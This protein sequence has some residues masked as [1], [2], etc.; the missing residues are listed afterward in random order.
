MM[1]NPIGGTDGS[2]RWHGHWCDVVRRRLYPAWAW[3]VLALVAPLAW[4]AAAL[5]PS[6]RSAWSVLR[7]AARLVIAASGTP[8]AVHGTAA[9]RAA[10]AP[11]IFVCNHASYLDVVVVI[12][13]VP[14]PVRF[15]AKAELGR[16]WLSGPPLRRIGT[17][18]VERFDRRRSLA[19]YRAIVEATRHG[20]AVLFFPE[21]TFGVR[22][23][24]LPF[25]MGAFAA[26]IETG[27]CVRPIALTGTRALLPS[28]AR[29]P[30]WSPIEISYGEPIPPSAAAD[31]WSAAVTLRDQARAFLLARLNEPDLATIAMKPARRRPR[32][33]TG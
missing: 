23:G 33:A 13:T 32:S 15:I 29:W 10:D 18:F 31:R 17:L 2:R 27:L 21:G 26:A 4:L 5:A 30:R 20:D 24:L 28:G 6:Q 7:C 25:Q 1:S 11:C 9:A 14:C 22:P 16:S 8:V 3:L 19:G 12:A